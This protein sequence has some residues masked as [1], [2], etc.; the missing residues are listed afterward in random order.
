[1]LGRHAAAMRRRDGMLMRDVAALSA[2]ASEDPRELDPETGQPI[3]EPPADDLLYGGM[4]HVVD[5]RFVIERDLWGSQIPESASVLRLPIMPASEF[6]EIL[7]RRDHIEVVVDYGPDDSKI[8][9][10][11]RI[12][13]VQM[14]HSQYVFLIRWAD[15]GSESV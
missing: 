4:A 9:R 11:A 15:T 3:G 2:P 8:V 1:M 12:M 6:V 10:E 7:R 14:G 5:D 13:D